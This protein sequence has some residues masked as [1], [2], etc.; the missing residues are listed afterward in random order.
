MIRSL[1]ALSLAVSASGTAAYAEPAQPSVDNVCSMA[2]CL[3]QQGE[4]SDLSPPIFRAF[5][6][7]A[8]SRAA[9][10]RPQVVRTE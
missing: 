3:M 7:E 10:G 5:L 4:N 9:V 6:A 8:A 1:L 2:D